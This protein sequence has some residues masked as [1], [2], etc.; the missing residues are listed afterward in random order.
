MANQTILRARKAIKTAETTTAAKNHL[1]SKRSNMLC[2][3]IPLPI[4]REMPK[5]YLRFA[6]IG[7]SQNEARAT[8]IK[9]DEKYNN[10]FLKIT[11][12][13]SR[14]LNDLLK[15]SA[16]AAAKKITAGKIMCADES[17]TSERAN[18]EK[19][20]RKRL[21]SMPRRL[22]NQQTNIG[23]ESACVTRPTL[24]VLYKF[25]PIFPYGPKVEMAKA[26]ARP[27]NHAETLVLSIL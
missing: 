4:P 27:E 10:T 23:R 18:V 17:A 25:K 13:L 7:A 1:P 6:I 26:D 11:R 2:A 20:K 24:N 8:E 15:D 21:F 16:N 22:Q 12:A 14:T 5:K 3:P 19:T 9:P